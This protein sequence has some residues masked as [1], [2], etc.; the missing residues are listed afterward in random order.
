V[1]AVV[2][3]A[4]VVGCVRVLATTDGDDEALTD[5][6]HEVAAAART[7]AL[8]FLRVD[9]RDME[10]LVDAVL[11][12]AT[13]DFA[14]QYAAQRDRLVSEAERTRATSTGEVVS[15]GVSELGDDT[16]T[17][18]VAANGTVTNSGAERP[19]RRFY[20]LRM[21]L[22]RED[23]RWLTSDVEFVR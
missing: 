3:V 13:G 1:L 8:A 6:Q 10:P 21:E 15:L 17:V 7:E 9:H 4:L 14:E 16:A 20:R 18:V 2:L 5:A 22:V 23:G 12:G 19:Q 11:A